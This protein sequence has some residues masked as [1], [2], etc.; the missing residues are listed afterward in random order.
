MRELL[1]LCLYRAGQYKA[2]TEE[3]ERYAEITGD[4][5]QH[6]VLMDCAR[7]LGDPAGGRALAGARRGVAHGARS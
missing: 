4:V 7:A 3:L 6:P 5:D 1:G 2:A